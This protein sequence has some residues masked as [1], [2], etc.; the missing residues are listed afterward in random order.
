MTGERIKIVPEV[1]TRLDD[2]NSMLIINASIPGVKKEEISIIIAEMNFRLS[3]S[4]GNILFEI[5]LPLCRQVTPHEAKASYEGGYLTIEVPVKKDVN[6]EVSI[7]V[8]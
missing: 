1:K 3:A 7:M 2:K 6:N 8:H 5:S 4:K